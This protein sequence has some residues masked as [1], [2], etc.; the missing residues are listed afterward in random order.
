[1]I[2]FELYAPGSDVDVT[3][4]YYVYFRR[5]VDGFFYDTD[6]DTFKVFGSLVD[7]KIELT[8]DVNQCSQ[9]WLPLL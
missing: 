3:N 4:N 6:D 5:D 1:M 7:G 8:E 2:E 9:P